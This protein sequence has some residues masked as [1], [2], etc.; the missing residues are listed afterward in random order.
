MSKYDRR[1]VTNARFNQRRSNEK[2]AAGGAS[3]WH[4]Q[5]RVP[6]CRF[7][8]GHELMG[9]ETEPALCSVLHGASASDSLFPLPVS[10]PHSLSLVNES[11]KR[12]SVSKAY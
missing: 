4:S 5:L 6:T 10:L 12:E 9:P 11:L 7:G 2:G 1:P 8:S 3:G